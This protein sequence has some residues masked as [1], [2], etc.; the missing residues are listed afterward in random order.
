MMNTQGGQGQQDCLT[1]DPIEKQVGA[2]V[3]LK[4]RKRYENCH[5]G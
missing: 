3:P 4:A 5:F 1:K 2:R